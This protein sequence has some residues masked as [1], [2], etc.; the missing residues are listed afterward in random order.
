MFGK[1]EPRLRENQRQ[2]RWKHERGIKSS[3]RSCG[4]YKPNG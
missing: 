2:L 3:N 4:S 1:E